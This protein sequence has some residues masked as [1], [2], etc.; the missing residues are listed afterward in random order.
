MSAAAGLVFSLGDFT[1]AQVIDILKTSAVRPPKIDDYYTCLS[2]DPVTGAER[3]VCG[4][5]I[6]NLAGIPAPT[7]PPTVSGGAVVGSTLT[8]TPGTWNGSPTEVTHQWLK[9]GQPIAGET[10]D[11]HVVATDDIGHTFSVRST[12]RK[13]GYPDFTSVSATLDLSTNAP[14][15]VADIGNLSVSPTTFTEGQPVTLSANFPDGIFMVTL[16]KESSPDVWTAVGTDESNSSGNAYFTNYQVN[17]TQ[18]VYARITSG[19]KVGRT[20]VDILTP[21]QPEVIAPT[22]PDVGNLSVDPTTFTEGQAVKVAANFPDGIFMVTLYK[23]TTS[24]T[25]TAVGTDESNSSGNAYFPNYAVNGTQ[26]LFARKGNG[27]R[28]EVDTLTPT[29]P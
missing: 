18:N 13:A 29:S 23:E 9:D 25:W 20:E 7:A 4:A 16:Y 15:E 10:G 12:A 3:N 14:S 22:G 28:T 19:T 21:A 27:D 1:A 26:R 17:G 11:S 8:M 6:L 24:G 2:D 5:G